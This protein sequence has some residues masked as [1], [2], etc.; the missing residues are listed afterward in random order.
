MKKIPFIVCIA[1]VCLSACS[2]A[3]LP[4]MDDAYYTRNNQNNQSNQ[5]NQSAPSIEYL[6]VQDTTV[7]IRIRQ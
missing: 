4:P 7:T 6:N 5:S 1:A 2:T 3:Q